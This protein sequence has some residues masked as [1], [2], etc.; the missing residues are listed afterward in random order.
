MLLSLRRFLAL[1]QYLARYTLCEPMPALCPSVR[2]VGR[3]ATNT[4]LPA[5]TGLT[6]TQKELRLSKLVQSDVVSLGSTAGGDF[7]DSPDD[8]W[9]TALAYRQHVLRVVERLREDPGAEVQV[10]AVGKH[11]RRLRA[12]A[13]G[14]PSVRPKVLA[15]IRR[16]LTGKEKPC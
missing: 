3:R 10:A 7:P 14:D 11:G 8:G 4:D 12:W 1:P 13:P 5:G 16:A 6:R 2:P 15:A 9:A